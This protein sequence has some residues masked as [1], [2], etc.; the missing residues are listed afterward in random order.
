[1]IN[2]QSEILEPESR[3]IFQFVLLIFICMLFAYYEYRIFFSIIY[4]I[5]FLYYFLSRRKIVSPF[6]LWNILFILLCGFSISWSYNPEQTFIE[7]RNMIELAIISNLLIA[8]IDNK[9]KVISAYK[10]FIYAGI[11]FIIRLLYEIPLSTWLSTRLG[12]DSDFNSNRIGLYLT[13]SAICTLHLAQTENKK[14]YYMLLSLFAI[15]IILTGSRKAFLMLLV[16]IGVLYFLNKNT[17]IHKK[18]LSVPLILIILAIGYLAV[19]NI[20]IFYEILGSRLESMISIFSGEGKVDLS[21]R[22]RLEMIEV[23]KFL[24]TEKPILGYGIGSYS[25][26][27]GFNAYSHNNYIELL[28]GLGILGAVLY[29][30]MIVYIICKLFKDRKEKYGNPLLVIL[31]LLMIMDYALVSYNGPVYQ[32]VVALGF[33]A[34]KVSKIKEFN[35]TR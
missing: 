26:V 34:T 7:T 10:Y 28:V 2:S 33:A 15:V 13:I 19:M 20:P 23:G 35:R 9:N 31:L 21:A 29:Y 14:R 11:A 27:S 1:M 24:F 16:G 30:S 5:V 12:A 8:F 6:I 22:T 18:I 25:V 17:N 4:A 3:N 32:F